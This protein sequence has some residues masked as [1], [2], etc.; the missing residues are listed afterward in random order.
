MKIQ[1]NLNVIN[2]ILF[3]LFGLFTPYQKLGKVKHTIMIYN[4]KM[5]LFFKNL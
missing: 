3:T 2:T 4:H 1:Q 5:Q